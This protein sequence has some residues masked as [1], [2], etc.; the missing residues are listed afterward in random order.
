[1]YSITHI[2][3]HGNKIGRELGFPTINFNFPHGTY[4]ASG[5]Y[6]TRTLINDKWYKSITVSI[7]QKQIPNIIT[8]VI[9]TH[10]LGFEGDLYNQYVKVEFISFLGKMVKVSSTDELKQI[11]KNFISLVS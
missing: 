10:I 9:E 8:D 1:P 3:E 11:I 6:Q 7:K 2:V 5:V 4:L